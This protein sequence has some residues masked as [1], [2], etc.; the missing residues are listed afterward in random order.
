MAVLNCGQASVDNHR[1]GA[2]T[3]APEDRQHGL[4][5]CISARYFPIFRRAQLGDQPEPLANRDGGATSKTAHISP[6]KKTELEFQKADLRILFSSIRLVM[7]W[8][9]M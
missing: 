4:C 8:F 7:A 5:R 6:T 1:L 3:L 2:D 9:I